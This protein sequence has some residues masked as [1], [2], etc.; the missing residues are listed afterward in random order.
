MFKVSFLVI[1]LSVLVLCVHAL[2]PTVT[3]KR[4]ACKRGEEYTTCG[5]SCAEKCRNSKTQ[6]PTVCQVGCFCIKGYSR[7]TNGACVP[8]HMCPYKNYTG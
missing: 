4:P 1:V 3:T 8:S 6:C 2:S 7:N 5:N